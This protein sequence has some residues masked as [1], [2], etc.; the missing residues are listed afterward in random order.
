MDTYVH[1]RFRD[2]NW[3]KVGDKNLIDKDPFWLVEESVYV[4]QKLTVSEAVLPF[5]GHV[6]ILLWMILYSLL[7]WGK[8]SFFSK[9]CWP[10]WTPNRKR[11]KLEHFLTTYTN[12]S[13]KWITDW[14]VRPETFKTW[15]RKYRQY[16]HWHFSL[17]YFFFC[18]K[19]KGNKSK[20]K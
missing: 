6:E 16:S 12:I 20:N 17:P 14:N 2:V 5:C 4:G 8:D 7:K 18:L 19:G 11:P 15:K 13:S 1:T 3:S 10:Y 9:W